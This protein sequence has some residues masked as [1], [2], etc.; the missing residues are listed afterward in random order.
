MHT[1]MTPFAALIN[2]ST[3]YNQRKLT[4][5]HIHVPR[6]CHNKLN[7]KAVYI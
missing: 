2:L 5:T 1:Y 6:T 4:Y 7:N 3:I